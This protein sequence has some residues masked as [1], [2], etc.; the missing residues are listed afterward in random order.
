MTRLA[1]DLPRQVIGAF[2]EV[3]PAR[4]SITTAIAADR[5]G[6]F[7]GWSGLSAPTRVVAHAGAVRRIR[8]EGNYG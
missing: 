7:L 2:T 8:R 4:F 1:D 3:A 6:A 5:M